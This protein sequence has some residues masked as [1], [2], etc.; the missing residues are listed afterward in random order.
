VKGPGSEGSRE[1]EGQGANKPGSKSSRERIGQ[2]S[3]GRFAP[4]SE[5]VGSEKAVNRSG[6]AL[7]CIVPR[8]FENYTRCERACLHSSGYVRIRIH[9]TQ[10]CQ[11]YT[12]SDWAWL[13]ASGY[14]L[15]CIAPLFPI[16]TR[17]LHS[18]RKIFLQ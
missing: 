13:Y 18:S 16:G 14:P 5:L 1:R 3:I 6:Y 9:G 17:N 7:K 10:I 4:G 2:G 12:C 15:K 11:K 8:L